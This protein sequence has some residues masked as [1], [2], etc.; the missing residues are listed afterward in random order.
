MKAQLSYIMTQIPMVST[1]A[2]LP[3]SQPIPLPLCG[4]SYNYEREGGKKGVP[5]LVQ[6][7]NDMQTQP[8]GRAEVL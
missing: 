8:I 6:V 3:S 5:C 2:A 4:V 1:P 7:L